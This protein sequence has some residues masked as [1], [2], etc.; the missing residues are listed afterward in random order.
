[1]LNCAITNFYNNVYIIYFV[2]RKMS[3]Y[4]PPD[5]ISLKNK[6]IGTNCMDWKQNPDFVLIIK[7]F[8]L[9]YT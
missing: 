8:I 2:S 7:Q 3:S 6:L 4:S 1:M 9:D 5:V